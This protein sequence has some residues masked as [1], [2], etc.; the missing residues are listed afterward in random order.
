MEVKIHNQSSESQV[1]SS[2]YLRGY[3]LYMYHI[4]KKNVAI[5]A[6]YETY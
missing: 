4:A 5:G 3:S 2:L 1:R 6:L